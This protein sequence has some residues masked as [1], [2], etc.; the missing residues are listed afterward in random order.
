MLRINAQLSERCAA[1]RWGWRMKG[2]RKIEESRDERL[3]TGYVRNEKVSVP[4]SRLL[5]N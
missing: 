4:R 5:R 1:T 2:R 3:A